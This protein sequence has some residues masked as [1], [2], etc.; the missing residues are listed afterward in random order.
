MSSCVT[1]Q[2]G[3][4]PERNRRP[5]GTGGGGG[6]T[7]RLPE[8][9]V[10]A[11]VDLL[12]DGGV[13]RE[14]DLGV[15]R[16][17]VADEDALQLVRKV[18]RHLRIGL[19]DVAVARVGH[20]DE[21]ALRE[22]LEDLGE[23]E[24]PDREGGADVAEVQRPGVEAAARVGA[25]DELHV[26]PRRLLRRRG[27]VVEVEVRDGAGPVRVHVRHVQPRRE[28]PGE[29]VEEALLGQ[30]DLGEPQDVVDVA[31]D[32]QTLGRHQVRRRVPAVGPV[33]VDVQPLELARAVARSKP[34]RRVLDR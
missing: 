12:E 15:G 9:E 33:G 22:G 26:D 19:H 27:Q 18:E 5:G 25:V 2:H 6:W 17:H 13:V 7:Y 34:A 28:G 3:R 30:V 32:G 31:D 4:S 1:V 24:V 16:A 23:Q 21:L 29:G 14:S 8:E 10:L 11:P 20:Q